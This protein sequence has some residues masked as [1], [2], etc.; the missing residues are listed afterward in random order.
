MDKAEEK[1]RQE[2]LARAFNE[3]IVKKQMEDRLRREKEAEERK[4]ELAKRKEERLARREKARIRQLEEDRKVREYEARKRAEIEKRNRA[5]EEEWNRPILEQ[6]EEAIARGVHPPAREKVKYSIPPFALTG[7]PEARE[8]STPKKVWFMEA[9]KEL[10]FERK[11]RYDAWQGGYYSIRRLENGEYMIT[12]LNKEVPVRGN[13]I[14]DKY[15][16]PKYFIDDPV[17]WGIR[18]RFVHPIKLTGSIFTKKQ[19]NQFK[20]EVRSKKIVKLQAELNQAK[21]EVEKLKVRLEGQIQINQE[22]RDDLT[23]CKSSKLKSKLK[24]LVGK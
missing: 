4:L 8:I 22:L 19:K 21:T 13:I 20:A 14:V 11:I 6:I 15:G 2:E 10:T 12:T 9:R 16:E 17:G 23:S 3:R 7:V 5:I 24:K 18:K 1:K